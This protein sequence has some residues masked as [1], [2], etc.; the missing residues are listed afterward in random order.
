MY[1]KIWRYFIGYACVSQFCSKSKIFFMTICQNWLCFDCILIAK[2]RIVKAI[3][4]NCYASCRFDNQSK[5]RID[6]IGCDMSFGAFVLFGGESNA[7]KAFDTPILAN[8][9]NRFFAKGHES[10]NT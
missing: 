10:M 2:F 7:V 4:T 9:N 3:K 1:T 5:W 8:I 6:V